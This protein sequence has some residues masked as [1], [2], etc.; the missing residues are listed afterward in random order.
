MSSIPDI[1][2]WPERPGDKL[3][4]LKV[5]QLEVQELACS[6]LDHNETHREEER[7]FKVGVLEPGNKGFRH[8]KGSKNHL[9]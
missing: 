6:P 8:F 3:V 2:G 4:W 7:G 1:P 9:W 5:P